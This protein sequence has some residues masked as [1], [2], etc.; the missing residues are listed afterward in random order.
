MFILLTLTKAKQEVQIMVM[1]QG[2]MGNSFDKVVN[3]LHVNGMLFICIPY[4][5]YLGT[6]KELWK[7]CVLSS[8]A[9]KSGG[10]NSVT[11]RSVVPI[12]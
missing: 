7:L 5:R 12:F 2:E 1:N 3:N 4:N 9:T 10:V 11:S 8:L 6:G